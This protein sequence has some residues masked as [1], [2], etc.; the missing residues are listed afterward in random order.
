VRIL[1]VGALNLS[2]RSL[3]SLSCNLHP[4]LLTRMEDM[5]LRRTIMEPLVASL[6]SSALHLHFA[7]H[8][9]S[10]VLKD[11]SLV[12]HVLKIDKIMSFQCIGETI[13]QSIEKPILL[14]LIHIHIVRSI[15][16]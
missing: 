5:P 13:V 6:S 4:L 12:H 10:S 3:K 11:W 15:M 14:L 8:D 9:S 1:K 2:L 7:L 16:G